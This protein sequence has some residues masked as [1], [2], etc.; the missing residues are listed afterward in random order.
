MASISQALV[1]LIG[2]LSGVTAIIG[3]SPLRFY[4]VRLVGDPPVYP[5]VTYQ[6]I[7]DVN[8]YSHSGFSGL[9]NAR[10]QLTMW[11]RKYSDG[12]TLEAVLEQPPTAGINGYRGTVSSVKIDR[13][14]LQSG[15]TDFEE[16]TQIH[17]RTLD[18][19]IAYVA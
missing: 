3:T 13:I 8:S 6:R 12:E 7:D 5:Q 11:T 10:F 14:F 16:T 19:L 1:T 9:V 15:I 4:P 18:L 17:Q 2:S